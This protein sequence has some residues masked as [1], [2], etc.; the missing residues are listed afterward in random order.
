MEKRR[1]CSSGLFFT[2][3]CYLFLD[4]HV[5]TGTK[6]LLRDKWLCEISEV[7]ITR[8]DCTNYQWRN[9][10]FKTSHENSWVRWF[11]QA[12]LCYLI[13]NYNVKEAPSWQN[14]QNGYLPRKDSDQPR[15][16][17]SLIRESLGPQ[18]PNECT[19]KTDQTGCIPWLICLFVCV[20]V[21]RPSQPNGVMSSAVS[22]PNHTFT[23]QA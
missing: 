18:L 16:P 21:L 12:R 4:C 8:V 17:H 3:F 20:E 2:T 13:W 15:H 14:Q 1:N 9:A 5:K 7:E 6:I 23:G 10:T 22:L 11:G 19:A